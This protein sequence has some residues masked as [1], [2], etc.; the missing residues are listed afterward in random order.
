M[1]DLHY[2]VEGTSAFEF[3]FK[4]LGG[5]NRY[6]RYNAASE[7]LEFTDENVRE[8]RFTD[9]I[10]WNKSDLDLIEFL[11][12]MRETGTWTLVDLK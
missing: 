12:I 1:S 9:E 7:T 6:Y 2:F 4:S 8:I 11:D 5:C 3:G 10:K